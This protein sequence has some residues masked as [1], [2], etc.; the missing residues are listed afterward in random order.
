MVIVLT[1]S[2]HDSGLTG[3]EPLGIVFAEN[4]TDK[5]F[6]SRDRALMKLQE[7]AASRGASHVFNLKFDENYCGHPS[8][9]DWTCR[10]IGDAYRSVEELQSK[11]PPSGVLADAP[12]GEEAPGF[13]EFVED[14]TA[15]VVKMWKERGGEEPTEG[16]F[17]DMVHCFFGVQRWRQRDEGKK[18]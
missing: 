4:Y 17:S 14:A 12:L 15:A 6:R 10:V 18:T 3:L 2:Y 16:R 13:A 11:Q 5:R 1:Q 8:N 9:D 7:L